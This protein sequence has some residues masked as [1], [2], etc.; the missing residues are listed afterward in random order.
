MNDFISALPPNGIHRSLCKRSSAM[1]YESGTKRKKYSGSNNSNQ[2]ELSHDQIVSL[3]LQYYHWTALSEWV[4]GFVP[5]DLLKREMFWDNADCS[6][7]A[8]TDS[9][10]QARN[11]EAEKCAIPPEIMTILMKQRLSEWVDALNNYA[12]EQY[13]HNQQLMKTKQQQKQQRKKV[14]NSKEEQQVLQKMRQHQAEKLRQQQIQW[15]KRQR[16]D[17]VL[18]ASALRDLRALCYISIG[19]AREVLRRLTAASGAVSKTASSDGAKI[20]GKTS[21]SSKGGP[22]D[23]TSWMV[24]LFHQKFPVSN[25]SFSSSSNNPQVECLNLVCILLETKDYAIVSRMC[26][27]PAWSLKHSNRASKSDGKGIDGFSSGGNFGLLYIALR[28]G[29]QHLIGDSVHESGGNDASI[30]YQSELFARGVIRLLKDIRE[31]LLPG[32][33]I[34]SSNEFKRANRQ[35]GFFFLGAGSTVSRCVA[36]RR[37]VYITTANL[38]TV[39]LV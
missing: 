24:E 5:I 25:E 4:M 14:G 39:W 35:S 34:E 9:T 30:Q 12:Y 3:S 33:K 22:G 6:L 29:I 36:L 18:L 2:G 8:L 15:Q 7:S 37:S 31:I 16:R 23:G 20:G 28:C 11:T 26:Q 19:T 27:A 13:Q 32:N 17:G 1:D 21:R 10:P 38:N